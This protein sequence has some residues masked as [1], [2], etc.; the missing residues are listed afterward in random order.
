MKWAMLFIALLLV[1]SAG[2]AYTVLRKTAHDFSADQCPQCHAVTP[3]KGKRDTLR[4]TAPIPELCVRCHGDL[5]ESLTHP[6]EV[7]P[8][9]TALPDD[10]PLSWDG[11]MTC[12]TCHD[13]HADPLTVFSVTLPFLRRSVTGPAFCS[14]CHLGEGGHARMIGKAHMTFS[15]E[16]AGET[17]DSVSRECLSC[18]DGSIGP[19]DTMRAG[20]WRHGVALARFDPGGSHPIGVDYRLARSRHGGLHPAAAVNEAIKLVEGKV[21]CSSCHDPYSGEQKKLVMS[22]RGSRLCL[23]CHDK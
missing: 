13:I 23:S 20:S 11:K 9:E 12:S 7:V 21:G 8:V 19:N 16:D 14:A 3:V 5:G 15:P 17:I 10:L 2:A 6:V 4:M 18:H 1:L 22:N